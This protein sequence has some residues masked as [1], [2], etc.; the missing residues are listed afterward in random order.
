M[1][2]GGGVI[3]GI[4]LGATDAEAITSEE[5]LKRAEAAAAKAE[6]SPQA[7]AD[8]RKTQ[9]LE[10]D[11]QFQPM[12][13]SKPPLPKAPRADTAPVEGKEGPRSSKAGGFEGAAR[14]MEAVNT[15]EFMAPS[16]TI[17][18]R[19]VADTKKAPAAEEKKPDDK[20]KAKT[21]VGTPVDD[22]KKD[23]EKK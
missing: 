16:T 17:D 12:P 9:M 20:P 8:S 5:D 3:G 11:A 18:K 21:K 1:A 14:Q 10:I 13:R 6:K 22:P 19:P 23:P 4:G 2:I 7:S 15:Q